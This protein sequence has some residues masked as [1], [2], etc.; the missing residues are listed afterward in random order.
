MG[1]FWRFNHSNTAK[2][3]GK[4][5][6]S[7]STTLWEGWKDFCTSTR[8]SLWTHT[9]STNQWTP[10]LG[11][12]PSK[13]RVSRLLKSTFSWCDRDV[14]CRTLLIAIKMLYS[15]LGTPCLGTCNKW[16]SFSIV[17]GISKV[18][19]GK[20]NSWRWVTTEMEKGSGGSLCK[21]KQ[22]DPTRV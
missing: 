3:P 12:N 11:S 18:T 19:K 22:R 7:I 2:L 9:A 8:L 14:C 15:N 13:R 5:L 6:V 21:R 17:V 20:V 16:A 10:K 4:M 1:Y